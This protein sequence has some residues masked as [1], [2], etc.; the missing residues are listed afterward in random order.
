MG[1]LEKKTPVAREVGTTVAIHNIFHSLPVRFMQF[2]KNIKKE[3][4]LLFLLSLSLLF[5]PF[6]YYC[7][8]SF[9]FFSCSVAF[10]FLSLPSFFFKM[11]FLIEKRYTRLQ[12]VL[13]AYAV[14]CVGAR[15]TC[16]NQTNKG[17][18][19]VLSAS[20]NSIKDRVYFLFSFFILFIS[21]LYF[22]SF[23][24][25]VVVDYDW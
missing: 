13:Q 1:K 15:I 18:N 25:I 2:E 20:G 12:E 8:F 10:L 6:F 7:F 4:P 17:K 21:I 16:Y 24:F 22:I 11:M 5:F 9:H 3:Y 14:V 19:C 23:L